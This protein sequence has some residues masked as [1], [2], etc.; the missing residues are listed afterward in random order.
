MYHYVSFGTH[1][2]ERDIPRAELG[3]L[4]GFWGTNMNSTPGQALLVKPLGDGVSVSHVLT[5]AEQKARGVLDLLEVIRYVTASTHG[6]LK[7]YPGAQAAI[8]ALAA[9][10]LHK[11]T[12]PRVAVIAEI[13]EETRSGR[14]D[15]PEGPNPCTVVTG[16]LAGFAVVP[17]EAHLRATIEPAVLTNAGQ[18]ALL[19]LGS[20]VTEF[21]ADAGVFGSARNVA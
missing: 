11:M 12:D 21:V 15:Y 19:P 13:G 17:Q 8:G 5:E 16:R 4:T 10:D 3:Q 9:L 6:N 14:C 2:T 7:T 18:L 20:S 1:P